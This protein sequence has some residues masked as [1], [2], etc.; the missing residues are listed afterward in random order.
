MFF[1]NL[2]PLEI[3]IMENFIKA[4][5]KEMSQIF[6]KDSEHIPKTEVPYF[7]RYFLQFPSQL[8]VVDEI[9]P[10]IEKLET[11]T[12]KN[13]NLLQI[14]AIEKHIIT[15]LKAYTYPDNDKEILIEA[16]RVLD[17]EKLGYIDLHTFYSFMKSFG[18]VFTGEQIQEMEKFLIENESDF[19]SPMKI[20]P[21][22]LN[23]LKHNQYTTR[24]F[25]YES[26]ARKVIADNKKHF[27]GLMNEYRIF[28]E[29][30]KSQGSA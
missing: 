21:D 2:L 19:L 22:T 24:K 18:V 25:Y 8:Q 15:I 12:E 23:K 3:P 5:I 29:V 6:S 30:L 14:S 9:I 4:K 16:F 26:Y 11:D 7:I 20:N 27:E 10:E 1:A 17:S 28:K 13:K